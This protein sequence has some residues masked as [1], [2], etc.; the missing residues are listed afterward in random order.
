MRLKK[1]ETKFRNRKSRVGHFP[2][3]ERSAE[4]FGS[5]VKDV[6]RDGKLVSRRGA[7][8]ALSLSKRPRL[9]RGA[10]EVVWGIGWQYPVISGQ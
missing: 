6:Q 7:G 8:D 1:P 4:V 3:C 9:E 10:S 5:Y 2:I